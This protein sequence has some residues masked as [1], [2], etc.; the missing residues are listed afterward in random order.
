MSVGAAIALG[1]QLLAVAPK[2]IEGIQGIVRSFQ[3]SS[4]PKNKPPGLAPWDPRTVSVDGQLPSFDDEQ[5]A[6][7]H[8]I[9]RVVER[10]AP[11]LG[12]PGVAMGLVW[13]LVVNAH[14]ESRLRPGAHNPK[15]EDSRGLFQVNVRA[16][17]HLAQVNLYDPQTN[18]AVFVR[19]CLQDKRIRTK[20]ASGQASIAELTHDICL[21]VER[22]RHRALSAKKRARKAVE[23]LGRWALMPASTLDDR[24]WR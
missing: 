10:V 6:S 19:M 20:L 8:A 7:V 11:M 1:A 12:D 15:G 17:P 2:A 24:G 14:T 18:A 21:H 3:S 9:A 22:P 13:A 16:H 4:K 5:A 23:W